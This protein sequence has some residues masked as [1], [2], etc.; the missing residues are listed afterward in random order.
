MKKGGTSTRLSHRST[1]L[2]HVGREG[3]LL[4]GCQKR[5]CSESESSL[6]TRARTW[7]E[8]KRGKRTPGPPENVV[9]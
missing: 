9:E 2:R 8:E 4:R 3:I 6:A 1:T 5:H 7:L